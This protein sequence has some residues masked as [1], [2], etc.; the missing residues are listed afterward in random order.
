ML[1]KLWYA[2]SLPWRGPV[3]CIKQYVTGVIAPTKIVITSLTFRMF[4]ILVR[5]GKSSNNETGTYNTEMSDVA[6]IS[7]R[8]WKIQDGDL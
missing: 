3:E 1:H 6:Y 7:N 4:F 5:K 2:L 8:K